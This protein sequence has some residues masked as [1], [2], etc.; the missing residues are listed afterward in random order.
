MEREK[1]RKRKIMKKI[2]ATLKLG[3]SYEKNDVGI[4]SPETSEKKNEN[5]NG[6]LES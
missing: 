2:A 6:I 4:L 3:K 5:G 1:E